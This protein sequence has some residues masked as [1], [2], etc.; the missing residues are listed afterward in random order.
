MQINEYT[1]FDACWHYSCEYD[2]T[3]DVD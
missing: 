3:V 1:I 2:E